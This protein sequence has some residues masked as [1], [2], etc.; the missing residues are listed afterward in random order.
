MLT[1]KKTYLISNLVCGAVTP[2]VYKRQVYLDVKKEDGSSLLT[3]CEELT[4]SYDRNNVTDGH[5]WVLYATSEGT[6]SYVGIKD[7]INGWID[8]FRGPNVASNAYGGTGWHHV[9]VVFAEDGIRIYADSVLVN[10]Y[11][12]KTESLTG[13]MC[14]RDSFFTND[15]WLFDP[16]T[17]YMIRMLPEGFFYDMVMRIGACFVGGLILLAAVFFLW[18]KRQKIGITHKRIARYCFH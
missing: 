15:L 10:E 14:I 1:R 16:E 18:G 8:T 17:D 12:N 2:D 13:K 9:D 11:S 3:G 4:V 6:T 7:F 5:N